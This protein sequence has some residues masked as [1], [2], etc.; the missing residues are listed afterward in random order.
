MEI[1]KFTLVRRPDGRAAIYYHMTPGVQ[2]VVDGLDANDLQELSVVLDR[3]MEVTPPRELGLAD[4]IVEDA[5]KLARMIYIK[6][7][8]HRPPI[9]DVNLS[10]D[11]YGY[12]ARTL[13][14]SRWTAA[15]RG[16]GAYERGFITV[17]ELV[18]ISVLHDSG[19]RR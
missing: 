17:G 2:V 6:S 13:T 3:A 12:I 16:R 9:V 7:G 4:A 10:P 5:E 18:E 8:G 19:R 14:Y 1:G 11:V 15:L